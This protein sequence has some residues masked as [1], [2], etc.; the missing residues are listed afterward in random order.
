MVVHLEAW[1]ERRRV[2]REHHVELVHGQFGQQVGHFTLQAHQAQA[3]HLQHRAQQPLH[4]QLGQA[5]GNAHHQ[6]H[7]GALRRCTRQL[8]QG[9]A[10]LKDGFCLPQGHHARLGQRQAAPRRAQQ[11]APQ[12]SLELTHLGTY[13][14]DRHVQP[15]SG[16]G[17]A[18]LLGHHPEIVE[19]AV[20]ERRVHCSILRK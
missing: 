6:P 9:F 12:I 13:G 1:V 7:R 17:H 18:A 5:V 15:G 11:L 10:Q 14:L 3:L 8:G 4:L 20:V 16:I 19:V 2:V